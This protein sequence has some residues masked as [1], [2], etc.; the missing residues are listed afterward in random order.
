MQ[1]PATRA[2]DGMSFAIAP[3]GITAVL[4]PNGAGKTTTIEVCEGLRRPTSGTVRVLEAD[5][6]RFDAARRARLGVMLQSGG[7]P[8]AAR[9]VEFVGHIARLHADPLDPQLLCDRLGLHKLAATPYRRMSGGQ[10]QTLALAAAIVGRPELLILDEPT[11]GLD[12]AARIAT[13]ELVRELRDS[14]VTVMMSTHSMEEAERVADTVLV[15]NAGTVVAHG[16]LAELTGDDTHRIALHTA[17]P[18]DVDAM[19]HDLGVGISVT[20][21]DDELLI[22]GDSGVE[23]NAAVTAWCSSHGAVITSLTSGRRTLEDVFFDL[24]GR[25]LS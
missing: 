19:D 12:P 22:V 23:L 10:K 17:E 15:V 21:R 13:W 16:S 3:G 11:A 1:Y 6:L 8:S 4:G 20:M 25:D 18:I 2:V 14:G 24:T 5:P 7:I 9:A